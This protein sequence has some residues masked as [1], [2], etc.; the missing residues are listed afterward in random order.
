MNDM[1]AKP[2][3]NHK[4]WNF[5]GLIHKSGLT[6]KEIIDYM[7]AF[8]YD[9]KVLLIMQNKEQ[10]LEQK[11]PEYYKKMLFIYN[12]EIITYLKDDRTM[13]EYF[14]LR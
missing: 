2:N 1:L 13:F 11:Y 10:E 7:I 3:L 6:E 8:Q 5:Y 4:Q 14:H 12:N 9:E